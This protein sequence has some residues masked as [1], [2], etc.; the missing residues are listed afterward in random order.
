MTIEK[1]LNSNV[2]YTLFV[3]VLIMSVLVIEYTS[4]RAYIKTL[5]T[6]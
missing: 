2:F 5:V 4:V 3:N 6:L 1:E